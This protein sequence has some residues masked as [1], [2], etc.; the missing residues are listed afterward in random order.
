MNSYRTPASLVIAAALI[1]AALCSVSIAQEPH[2]GGRPEGG[3]H[4]EAPRSS[5][6]AP[7][8]APPPAYH[9]APPAAAHYDGR[10]QVF[11]GRYNHG[12]YY[13]PVGTVARA[14]PGEYRAYYH[15][16]A[17]YYFSAGVWYAPRGA[18][19]VVVTPPIGMSIA[20]LPPYYST[21][22]VAGVPYYYANSVYYTAA[23]DQSGY[24]VATPPPDDGGQGAPPPDGSADPNAQGGGSYAQAPPQAPAP[25]DFIIY[26]KQAQSKDQQAAD[27]YECHNWAKGQTGFDPTQPNGGVAAGDADRA[28]S[29]YDRAMAACLQGRGYQVN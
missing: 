10:G 6:P 8:P 9:G 15:G 24:M 14:L 19:F 7:R 4:A 12:R 26:P 20:V 16:G 21:L 23:P 3:G 17:P 1:G 28:H 27:E 22:W 29:N 25:S 13:A 11:D 18:G 2:G 5:A